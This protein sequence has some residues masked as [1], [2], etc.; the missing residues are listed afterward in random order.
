MNAPYNKNCLPFLRKN[1]QKK[2]KKRGGGGAAKDHMNKTD[3][4]EKN[5]H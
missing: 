1:K 3:E 5:S 4:T 2:K